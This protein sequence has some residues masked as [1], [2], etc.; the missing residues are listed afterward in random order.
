MKTPIWLR[1]LVVTNVLVVVAAAVIGRLAG[2]AAGKVVEQRLVQNTARRTG[3]FLSTQSLPFSDTLMGNLSRMFGTQFATLR[4]RDKQILGSSFSEADTEAL[5]ATA[6]AMGPSGTVRLGGAT[7]RYESHETRAD[8][9]PYDRSPE[10]LRLY[11]FVPRNEFDDAKAL[12]SRR[13]G[14]ITIPVVATASLLSLAFAFTIVRPIHRLAAEMEALAGNGGRPVA[15]G[16]TT[17][18]DASRRGPREVVKLAVAFDGLMERLAQAQQDLAHHERL[19]ALGRVAASVVHEL[20]NPL[21]GIRM[22]LR[23]LKDELGERGIDDESLGAG[24][25]EAERMGS[26]LDEL[27]DLASGAVGSEDGLHLHPDAMGAVRLDQVVASVLAVLK[28]RC[29]HSNVEVRT[30]FNPSA[31]TAWGDAARL[32]Q[33]VMNLVANAIE[34]M[35]LG[36]LVE[37]AVEGASPDLVRCTVSDEGEGIHVERPAELFEPFVTT[38]PNS[39][40]LGL[41]V[42][43]RI[44]EAHGGTIACRNTERGAAF[45]F[46]L[47]AAPGRAV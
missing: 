23:V 32:R 45:W 31:P 12:A 16:T 40:G 14:E 11:A 34:A 25:R 9:P 19:A 13:V 43:R 28:G 47:P 20:R 4:L 10:E 38:K 33:V 46:E 36:G 1:M 8:K 41:Y 42:S 37:I 15:P 26:Y 21:S 6:D 3:E 29:R 18:P 17:R 35:P 7:Y 5:Q 44:V 22:N 30:R 39:A 24:L 2:D 27:T